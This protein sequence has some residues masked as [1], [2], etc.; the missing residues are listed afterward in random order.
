MAPEKAQG[1]RRGGDVAVTTFPPPLAP[2]LT[3]PD[4]ELAAV[5]IRPPL[6]AVLLVVA[7][8]LAFADA[9]V[10]ALALPDL[11]GELDTTIVGVSWVLTTYALTVAVVAVPVA[12]LHRRVRPAVLATVGLGLFA[13]ASLAAGLASSLPFLLTARAVQ[14]VGATRRAGSAHRRGC[15]RR[16]AGAWRPRLGRHGR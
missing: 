9:S 7:V 2:P 6:A 8:A 12:L 10:V 1:A 14:G 13:L 5:R 11:Y 4:D 3:P 15:R 16:P